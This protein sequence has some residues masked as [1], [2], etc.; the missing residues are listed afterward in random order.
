MRHILT[1]KR[2]CVWMVPRKVSFMIVYSFAWINSR[3]NIW[4]SGNSWKRVFTLA[5]YCCWN[6]CRWSSLFFIILIKL[7]YDGC[8]HSPWC[9]CVSCVVVSFFPTIVW[10]YIIQLFLGFPGFLEICTRTLF[11]FFL[12]LLSH[13]LL[14]DHSY[15]TTNLQ[16]R[17]WIVLEYS[18]QSL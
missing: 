4:I 17:V 18:K 3:W 9:F 16:Y 13:N 6:R 12:F 8:Q 5:S 11:L 7:Q 10:S 1:I 14:S 2:N 15:T